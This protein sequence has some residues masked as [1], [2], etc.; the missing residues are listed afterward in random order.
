MTVDAAEI[1]RVSTLV[2]DL[3]RRDVSGL[4]H[5]DLMEAHDAVARLGRLAGTLQARFAGEIARRSTPDLPGGGLARRQGFGNAGAMVS[6]VTGGTAAGAMRAIE[7]GLALMPDAASTV[8][9][10]ASDQTD[11]SP[12]D[13]PQASVSPT[14]RYPAVAEAAL[15]GDLSVDAAGLITAGLETLTDR[16]PRDRV[17]DLER[18]LVEKAVHLAVHEVRSLVATAVARADLRGHEER[19]KRQQAERYIAWKEDHTGMVTFTGKLDAVTAAPIRTVIEQIVTHDF[20]ARRD[21]DP[22]SPDQ[23]SVGQMRA[24]AL[25]QICRHALGCKETDQSGVRTTIVV[26]MNKRDLDAGRGLGSIDG[27]HQPVSVGQLRR[28]AGDAGIVPEVLGGDSEVLDLGRSKRMFTGPQRIALIERDGGCAKCHAPPEHCEAHHIRWWEKGGRTDLA[29]GV[30]LCTRCHH[31][32]HRQ[33]WGI[34]VRAGTV[35]FIPPPHIDPARRP[36]PGGRAALEIRELD[37]PSHHPRDHS[38]WD[39]SAWDNS[40]RGDQPPPDAPPG[41]SADHGKA[42][43]KALLSA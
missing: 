37:P 28:L 13:A 12:F 31:D 33:G 34:V 7:A 23:R 8:G 15:A 22:A 4:S 14:P 30:M 17:H 21:Q 16:I 39:S 6:R 35:D 1:T 29:N 42:A 40:A 38:A 9:S 3:A 32:I 36:I 10:D 27:T 41:D 18:R 26:R 24:D 20:R 43:S 2:G 11:S 19:E 25:F 5:G